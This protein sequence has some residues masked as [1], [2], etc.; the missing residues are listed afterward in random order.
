MKSEARWGWKI[1][2]RTTSSVFQMVSV[3]LKRSGCKNDLVTPMT[4][5]K[6]AS[7]LQIFLLSTMLKFE[8]V[9][10]PKS[11][12]YDFVKR[13]LSTSAAKLAVRH[14]NTHITIQRC[15]CQEICY[16]IL[17]ILPKSDLTNNYGKAENVGSGIYEARKF[18]NFVA[19]VFPGS[20]RRWCRS[21]RPKSSPSR[22]NDRCEPPRQARNNRRGPRPKSRDSGKWSAPPR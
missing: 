7:P 10:H 4:L 18:R 12:T 1:Q 9:G 3:L 17:P 19:L 13:K 16:K 15:C 21:N 11:R 20:E 8:Q 22:S 14:N 5:S 6:R 2:G